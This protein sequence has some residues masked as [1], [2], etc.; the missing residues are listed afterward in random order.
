MSFT[1]DELK[2]FYLCQCLKCGWK[3]L[4]RDCM[5]DDCDGVFCSDC[6]VDDEWN[7]VDDWDGQD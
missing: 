7:A 6:W 4:S 1:Q 3:G 5:E 2:E